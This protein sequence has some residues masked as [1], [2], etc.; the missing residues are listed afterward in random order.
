MASLNWTVDKN[1]T[2]NNTTVIPHNKQFQSRWLNVLWMFVSWFTIVNN[3]CL[4][5][6]FKPVSKR[7]SINIYVCWLYEF[8]ATYICNIERVILMIVFLSHIWPFESLWIYLI[9]DRFLGLEK[10]TSVFL[11]AGLFDVIKSMVTLA[12]VVHACF[13]LA[14]RGLP[15]ISRLS[16]NWCCIQE[17]VEVQT[18][19]YCYCVQ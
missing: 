17:L 12:D 6:F 1:C 16:S 11:K 15:C 3:C 4:F 19:H 2:L 10:W 7:L 9:S 14:R 5:V 13:L 18:L 8:S